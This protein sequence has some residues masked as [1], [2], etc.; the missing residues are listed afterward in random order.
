MPSPL[1]SISCA[2]DESIY[3]LLLYDSGG[4][5]WQGAVFSIYSS[6]LVSDSFEES[7]LVSGTLVDGFESSEWICLADGCYEIVVSSGSAV[8]EISFTI[9]DKVGVGGNYANM[10][11]MLTYVAH[12]ARWSLRAPFISLH[13]RLLARRSAVTS[14]I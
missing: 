4:D 12:V 2:S 7:V 6:S 14:R 10:C 3:R 8:T 5:G 13:V 1:P 9:V 11:T